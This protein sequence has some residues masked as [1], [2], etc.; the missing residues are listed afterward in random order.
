ML[1]AQEQFVWDYIDSEGGLDAVDEPVDKIFEYLSMDYYESKNKRLNQLMLNSN[2]DQV[3][4]WVISIF[5]CTLVNHELTY[6]AICGMLHHKIRSNYISIPDKVRT[7]AEMIAITS[8]TGLI[9]ITKQG[10]GKHTLI[11]SG[12]DLDVDIPIRDKHKLIYDKPEPVLTNKRMLLGHTFNQHNDEICLDHTNRM[13]S[14][15]MSLNERII[16][17][18]EEIPNTEPDTKMTQDQWYKFME[19][20]HEKYAEFIANGN[21]GY[22]EHKYDTRGRSYATGYHITTQGSKYKKAILELTNKELVEV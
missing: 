12:Y 7:I 8:K 3:R 2:L 20:S 14:I 6:Q 22:L 5:T 15:Q 13:N 1:N 17:A 11:S 9:V 18:H 16:A 19:D 10:P 21:K 4:E